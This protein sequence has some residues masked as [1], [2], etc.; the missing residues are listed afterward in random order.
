MSLRLTREHVYEDKLQKWL[1]IGNACPGHATYHA[2]DVPQNRE[3]EG[4]S[5]TPTV[6]LNHNRE[7]GV[8][9]TWIFDRAA[10]YQFVLGCGGELGSLIMHVLVPP[11]TVSPIRTI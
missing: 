10:E 11:F 3:R 1:N 7:I 9:T 6:R 5:S 4:P 2:K 8:C